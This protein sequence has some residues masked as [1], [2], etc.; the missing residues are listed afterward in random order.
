[1]IKSDLFEHENIFT[2][3]FVKVIEHIEQGCTAD[4]YMRIINVHN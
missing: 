3:F 2:I 1:M 4:T